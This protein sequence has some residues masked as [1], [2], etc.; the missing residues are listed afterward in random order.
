MMRAEA[1][2]FYDIGFCVD[3]YQQEIVLNMTFHKAFQLA[4]KHVWFVLGWYRPALFQVLQH[5]LQ[6]SDFRGL[7]LIALQVFLIL[8]TDF[9][10]HSDLI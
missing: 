5:L 4:G 8:R 7:V 6:S 3:P 10:Y 9:Q 1:Y 2:Q